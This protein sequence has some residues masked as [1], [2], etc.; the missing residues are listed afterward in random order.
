MI[1]AWWLN[2]PARWEA[3]YDGPVLPLFGFIFFPWTCLWYTVFQPTGFDL[4]S[5]ILLAFA[6]LADLATWGVGAFANRER[7]SF[8]RDR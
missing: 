5:L 6:L 2:D 4:L 8:Y 7:V 1:L 3:V